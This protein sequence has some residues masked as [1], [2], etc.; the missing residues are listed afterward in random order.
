MKKNC[1]YNGNTIIFKQVQVED[2]EFILSL[3]LDNS[4]N[5]Y[6]NET[7]PDIEKQRQWIKEQQNKENDYYFIIL[8]KDYEKL[9]TVGIYEIN[10]EKKTFNW[11]RWILKKS[12][13]INV[14]VES[15]L[16]TYKVAFNELNLE[17]ALSDVR[18]ENTTVINFHLSY[19]AFI[20]KVDKV[21][22]Y[23]KFKIDQYNDLLIKY[24]RF[25]SV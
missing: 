1:D 16:L 2:A 17:T 7:S 25:I 8:N 21:N 11:G 4:L 6:L 3:R 23:Y 24:R 20:Y 10:W 5:K 19:G 18:I 13:S 15:M 12:T 9:G 22:V 14:A